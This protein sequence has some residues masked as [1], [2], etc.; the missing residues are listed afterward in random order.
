M[1]RAE[2]SSSPYSGPSLGRSSPA[3]WRL[4][5]ESSWVSFPVEEKVAPSAVQLLHLSPCASPSR[6]ASLFPGQ[7]AVT[8]LG[9]RGR[10]EGPRRVG[11]ERGPR[12]RA[13]GP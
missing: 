10:G 2:E 12:L 8:G 6:L 5:F 9:L 13:G 7:R 3:L 11:L 4:A 1:G